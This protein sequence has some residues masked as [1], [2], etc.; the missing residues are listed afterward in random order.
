MLYGIEK[1][2][3]QKYE[4]LIRFIKNSKTASSEINEKIS[5]MEKDIA[6]YSKG[7]EDGKPKYDPYGGR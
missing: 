5:E 6:V 4:E 2:K 7:F 3:F 1:Y